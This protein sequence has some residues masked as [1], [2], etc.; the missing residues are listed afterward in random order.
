MVA[1]WGTSVWIDF[2][3]ILN[4]HP[5]KIFWPLLSHPETL[6]LF[7]S[8]FSDPMWWK[9]IPTGQAHTLAHELTENLF[10]E[11]SLVL[12]VKKRRSIQTASP[13]PSQNWQQC[14]LRRKVQD[15]WIHDC[16]IDMDKGELRKEQKMSQSESWGGK[17]RNCSLDCYRT[18][19]SLALDTGDDLK[20]LK[21]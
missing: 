14:E 15:Q 4:N 6:S 10:L 11:S 12:E 9:P 5:L 8:C 3:I 19:F 2:H 18:R 13:Q 21:Q 1:F 17:K 16:N 7:P 20:V